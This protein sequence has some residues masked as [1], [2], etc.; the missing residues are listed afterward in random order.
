MKQKLLVAFGSVDGRVDD[1]GIA[2]AEAEDAGAHA[3][4]CGPVGRR[5][6]DDASL[7]Y[8]LAAGLK[9]RLDEN[10]GFEGLGVA[11]GGPNRGKDQRGGD[12]RYVHG[13]EGDAGG[14]LAGLELAGIGALHEGDAG[15]AA[16]FFSD[17]AVAGV[18]GED[19]RGT[20]LKHAVSEASGGGADVEAEAVGEADV[21]VGERGFEL[22]AATADVAQVFPQQ[23]D[24]IL[25]RDGMAGLLD[26]LLVDEHAAGEDQGLCALAAG[27]QSPVDEQL[28]EAEARGAGPG[29]MG[30]V[31][32]GIL[33]R[34]DHLL[35]P[36][37]FD[38]PTI[39]DISY[40]ATAKGTE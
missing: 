33:R 25:F 26:L 9:L 28:V 14:Q 24:G 39:R 16:E 23:A 38:L 6:T 11:H 37:M 4:D 5:I 19:L 27:D 34:L 8:A 7:P 10:D 13:E 17:L 18:D 21:P 12:E 30:L 36:P 3:L 29:S 40:C 22:E 32:G 31:W 15:I 20:V 1:L 2:S 35:T